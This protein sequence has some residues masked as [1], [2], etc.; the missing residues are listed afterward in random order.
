M[1]EAL[2]KIRQLKEQYDEADGRWPELDAVI[3]IDEV[4]EA[5]LAPASEPPVFSF[6]PADPVSFDGQGGVT[7]TVQTFNEMVGTVKP[8][9]TTVPPPRRQRTTPPTDEGNRTPRETSHARCTRTRLPSCSR[10]R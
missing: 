4:A 6:N 2:V 1:R 3:D 9:A 5:A 7:M 8:A 10:R